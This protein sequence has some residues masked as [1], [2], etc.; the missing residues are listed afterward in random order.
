MRKLNVNKKLIL[1][2]LIMLTHLTANVL[3]FEDKM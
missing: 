1:P 3:L 2:M